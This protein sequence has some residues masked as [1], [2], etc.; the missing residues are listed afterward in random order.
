[1]EGK[2]AWNCLADAHTR[3]KKRNLPA[4][5]SIQVVIQVRNIFC[6]VMDA[7]LKAAMGIIGS[8]FP[9]Q[10]TDL[11]C[12]FFLSVRMCE[13]AGV[14][15]HTCTCVHTRVYK[16]AHKHTQ[17]G[18]ANQQNFCKWANVL[19]ISRTICIPSLRAEEGLRYSRSGQAQRM[20]GKEKAT[21]QPTNTMRLYPALKW[22][23]QPLKKRTHRFPKMKSSIY[24]PPPSL[25]F[26]PM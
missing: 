14:P 15:T 22:P 4:Y 3:K 19:Q 1:M 6:F 20:W 24:G 7:L 10:L 8:T 2:R 21:I 5:R 18:S 12:F 11:N 16:H 23:D 17:R 26:P 9:S 25:Y 13:H